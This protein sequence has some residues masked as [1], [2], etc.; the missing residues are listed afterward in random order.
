MVWYLWVIL[1]IFITVFGLMIYA[2]LIAN[3]PFRGMDDQ[4]Q[5]EYL[6]TLRQQKKE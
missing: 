5:M 1:V 4:A 2:C 3:E 6:K